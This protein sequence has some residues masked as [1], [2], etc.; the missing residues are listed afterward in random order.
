MEKNVAN[1][2]GAVKSL[3]STDKSR[4]AEIGDIVKAI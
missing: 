3:A 2:E 4:N 1:C